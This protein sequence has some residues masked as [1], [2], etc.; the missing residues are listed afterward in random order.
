VR[1]PDDSKIVPSSGHA[2]GL[3]MDSHDHC[4]IRFSFCASG[5]KAPDA[6]EQRVWRVLVSQ[7]QHP[8]GAATLSTMVQ[9]AFAIV[10]SNLDAAAGEQEPTGAFGH[11]T[12]KT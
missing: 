9:R 10:A 11:W 7:H 3:R 6:S 5:V 4:S 8:L 1:N 2:N 12:I